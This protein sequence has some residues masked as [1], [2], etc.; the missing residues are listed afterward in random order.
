MFV[1]AV[2]FWLRD[3]LTEAEHRQFNEGVR[4]LI[5]IDGVKMGHIGTPASTN[6]PVIDRSYSHAL[7]VVFDDKDA[8]DAYQEDPIHRTFL[9]RCAPF[10][11]RLQIY[12]SVA[13]TAE[14]LRH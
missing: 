14:T 7:I 1:H 2:Y 10:W 12:D 13:E 5:A 3:D 4:S 6:R 11:Q 9:E 8:H